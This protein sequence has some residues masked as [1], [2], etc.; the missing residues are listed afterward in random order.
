MTGMVQ[1]DL[2]PPTAKYKEEPVDDLRHPASGLAGPQPLTLQ[3]PRT[4]SFVHPKQHPASP[5]QPTTTIPSGAYTPHALGNNVIHQ[6]HY[7]Q[8]TQESAY[9]TPHTASY[10]TASAPGHYPSSEIMATSAQ[11]QR[12][13]PPIY[14]T[15]QSSSP[16]SVASQT[17]DPHGRSIYAQSP[18]MTPQIY[19]YQPYPSMNPV[20]PQYAPHP[21]PQQHPLTT[22]PLMMPHQTSAAQVHPIQA[23]AAVMS[24]PRS[25][26]Q[27][28][29]P[30]QRAVLNPPHPGTAGT[31]IATSSVHQSPSVGTSSSAAPGP[32][33]ATTPLVVRQDS[34]GVQW[35]AFEYS[36]DRVKMEYTIRCDVES[37]NVD[38]LS[39]EFKTE[40]CVYPRACCSKD[41]YRG[42]RLVYE[43]E[44]NAVGWA[45]ADL[46]PALRGKRGLIQRA[47]D[48]WRN[49]NQDPRLRSRRV[50]RMAKINKR[51][52]VPA[53]PTAHMA[54]TSPVAP[55][56]PGN[57]MSTGGPRPAVGPLMGPPQ[58][59]HHHAHPDTVT[60]N[61]EVSGAAEFANA[62]HRPSTAES[63]PPP[64]QTP[65]DIRTAQVF[66]GYQAFPPPMAAHG[67][68]R[69]PSMPPLL[70]DSGIGALGRHHAVATSTNRASE[71]EIDDDDERNPD[72]DDLFGTLPEG[73]RRKFILVD[74]TQRGCRVRVKVM[75]DNVDMNEIPDS[76]RMSNSV[77]PRTYF[78]VQM[79]NPPNR[80]VPGKRYFKEEGEMDDDEESAT[81]GRTMVPAPSL[82]G[83]S[84][85]AV[86]KISRGRR[87]KEV[88]LNDLG[89]RMSWS[90]SR[91]FSGRMLFLQRSLDAYRNKM[92]STM[93]VGGQDVSSIPSHFETRAGKR[94]FL[95][96]RKRQTSDSNASKRSAEEV[97]A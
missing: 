67:D 47:V 51:Q 83:E 19:G 68:P 5:H 78:P 29:T 4:A 25:A 33:P 20:P 43:T 15:P 10:A 65:T 61:E 14:H 91:V 41:Q 2:G 12:P 21:S 32:I 28:P 36:R 86:P 85:V 69:G 8:P 64:G 94:R 49:S 54:T 92:R 50:R 80:V 35:I 60:G 96:R 18:Q 77:F 37:V 45:L 70:R 88:L 22:Q 6:T 95:E 34:N 90:Q 62:T 55:G 71:A 52:T 16:A 1:T 97:E 53:H 79:K 82:D 66:H 84:E 31:S 72:N 74:D 39:Q 27:Q 81:I 42:N 56:I 87:K 89:Y 75:L 46:N 7:G 3:H 17:H 63:H 40:N 73:K 48:S 93:V 38:T 24:S 26:T 30:E 9:Y 23:P 57:V 76:Y 44:C 59:H 11:M 58:L 13:Y